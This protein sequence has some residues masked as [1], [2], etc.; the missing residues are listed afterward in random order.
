M[1][2][3][4]AKRQGRRMPTVGAI[5]RH[6]GRTT[7]QCWRCNDRAFLVR[8]H[9]VDRV[10]GGSDD[11]SNLALL[12]DWCHDRMRPFREDRVADAIAYTMPSDPGEHKKAEHIRKVVGEERWAAWLECITEEGLDYAEQVD[13]LV[14]AIGA[15]T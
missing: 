9:L 15:H 10:F 6:H 3:Q 5:A 14:N 12:C 13:I 4:N 2:T 11:V 1:D 7:D 8:A